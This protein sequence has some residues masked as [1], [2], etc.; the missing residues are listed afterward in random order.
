[1]L[2]KPRLPKSLYSIFDYKFIVNLIVFD[3]IKPSRHY[4][5]CHRDVSW[6]DIIEEIFKTKSKRRKQDRF[7][8][9]SDK[10]YILCK[11]KNKILWVI[12]AKPKK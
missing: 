3:A 7:E 2:I 6:P 1:M 10:Y 8:I 5:K 4:L 9:E 12:N 11:L